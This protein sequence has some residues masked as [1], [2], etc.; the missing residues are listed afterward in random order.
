MKILI[1]S[2]PQ[3]YQR[4]E[5]LGDWFYEGDILHINV[6]DH[7]SED[8][9]LLI[10]FHELVEVKLCEK[11]GITQKQVDDFDFNFKSEDPKEEPGDNKYSPYRKEHR[12]SMLMEHLF[13]HE[14][15]I[16]NYG[17]VK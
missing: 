16:E 6:S 13:A 10:A 12:F 3:Q 17:I 9:Q 4:Y 15:G 8:E 5:T 7:L 1:E 2:I 11:R 14:L